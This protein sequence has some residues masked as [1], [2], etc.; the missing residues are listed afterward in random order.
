MT[1]APTSNAPYSQ[2][3]SREEKATT[4]REM[5]SVIS[6]EPGGR[7]AKPSRSEDT[8]TLYPQLLA[9]SPWHSDPVPDE[10]PFG[11]DIQAAEP[12]GTPSEIERSL[13]A[14]VFS[15]PDSAEAGPLSPPA[16]T[17]GPLPPQLPGSAASA[18]LTTSG[19][20]VAVGCEVGGA[21]PSSSLVSGPRASSEGQQ[22]AAPSVDAAVASVAA[23]A[24][25]AEHVRGGAALSSRESMT[26]RF[27]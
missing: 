23:D 13:T 25:R 27:G 3:A 7:W 26:R 1:Q 10:E 14:G 17:A 22:L 20:S 16:T 2:E 12:C 11:V 4:L 15:S 19:A 5:H 6:P 21:D 8:A 24:N 9:S 18:P